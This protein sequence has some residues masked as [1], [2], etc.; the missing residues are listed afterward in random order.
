[1]MD[2]MGIGVG[3]AGHT[4]GPGSGVGDGNVSGGGTGVGGAVRAGD[5]I[6][7]ATDRLDALRRLRE[8]GESFVRPVIVDWNN[9]RA[10]K[11]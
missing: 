7:G 2:Y 10:G 11:F 9:G 3:H 6:K 1:M 4:A 5:L 8:D